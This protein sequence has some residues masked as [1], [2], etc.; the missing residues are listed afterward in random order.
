VRVAGSTEGAM[1]VLTGRASVRRWF[2]ALMTVAEQMA[3]ER[4]WPGPAAVERRA[5]GLVAGSAAEAVMGAAG[6]D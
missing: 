3:S 6:A 4:A 5:Q 1:V 2:M